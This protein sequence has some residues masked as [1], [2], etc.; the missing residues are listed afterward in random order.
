M[1]FVKINVCARILSQTKQSSKINNMMKDDHELD[2][3]IAI[4]N[5]ITNA[6]TSMVMAPSNTESETTTTST[7]VATVDPD[8]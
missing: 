8:V 3:S 1:E 7:A 2:K 5:A 6:N 4:T